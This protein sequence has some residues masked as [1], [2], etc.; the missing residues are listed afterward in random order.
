MS[1]AAALVLAG[2][3]LAGGTFALVNR[4]EVASYAQTLLALG[5]SA[6]ASQAAAQPVQMPA[7]RVTVAAVI[8]RKG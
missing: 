4:D 5:S 6:T 1:F 3:V 8:S 2:A 7:V